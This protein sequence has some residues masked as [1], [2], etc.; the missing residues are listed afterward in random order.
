[1]S[2]DINPFGVRM[3]PD[4]KEELEKEAKR[5]GRSL[6]AEIIDRLKRSLQFQTDIVEGGYMVREAPRAYSD[7]ISEVEKQ[8][9]QV[10]RRLPI[11]KQLGLISLLK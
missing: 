8:L 9:L 3:Q 6:N 4:L 7:D 1:M 5:N 10:F 2:R 11:E